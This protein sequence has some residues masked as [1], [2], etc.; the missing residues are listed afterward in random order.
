MGSGSRD[1]DRGV[2]KWGREGNEKGDILCTCTNFLW[3]ILR[4]Y[5]ANVLTQIK[6]GK[7]N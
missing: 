1:G 2:G 6:I 7:K 3:G 5:T 4:S